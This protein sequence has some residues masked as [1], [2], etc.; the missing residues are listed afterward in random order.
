MSE[1]D[2]AHRTDARAGAPHD[3]APRVGLER[4]GIPYPLRWGSWAC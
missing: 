2:D 1:T 4:W 3:G